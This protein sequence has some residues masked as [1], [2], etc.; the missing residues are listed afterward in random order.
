[1]SLYIV[2]S[3]VLYD[4]KYDGVVDAIIIDINEESGYFYFESSSFTFEKIECASEKHILGYSKK[5]K[6]EI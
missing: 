4:S 2:G 1:M 3:I 6:N 5:S